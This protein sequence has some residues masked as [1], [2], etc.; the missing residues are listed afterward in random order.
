MKE[1]EDASWLKALRYHTP[2][3]FNS[4]E[5]DLLGYDDLLIDNTS[6]EN[7]DEIAN[8]HANQDET[9]DNDKEIECPTK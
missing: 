6:D 5:D 3:M 4:D 2:N 8:I 9:S 7:Y 1:L